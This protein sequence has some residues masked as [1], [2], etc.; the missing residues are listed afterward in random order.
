MHKDST[1]NAVMYTA[2][3]VNEE[4]DAMIRVPVDLVNRRYH[5]RSS[6]LLGGC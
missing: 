1:R 5:S 3:A 6:G 2:D 4:L